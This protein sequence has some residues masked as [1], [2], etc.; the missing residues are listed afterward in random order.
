MTFMD[1]NV[2]IE[3][4]IIDKLCFI[5]VNQYNAVA[6]IVTLKWGTK[7]CT[8]YE[9]YGHIANS[10]IIM[11]TVSGNIEELE[12]LGDPKQDVKDMNV[13]VDYAM[14]KIYRLSFSSINNKYAEKRTLI[15]SDICGSI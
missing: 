12:I 2:Y 9:R 13:C 4:D 6:Q 8:W 14:R 1:G 15:H 10:I 3:M 11:L 5:P 7:L